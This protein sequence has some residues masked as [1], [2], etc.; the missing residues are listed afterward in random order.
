MHS[1]ASPWRTAVAMTTLSLL[2]VLYAMA[3]YGDGVLD[4][5][6]L[7]DFWLLRSAVMADRQHGGR[8]SM[9]LMPSH[10]GF[11][12]YRPLTQIAYF[13]ALRLL[14]GLDAT[15]FHLMQILVFA[16]NAILALAVARR[17]TAS[18][19]RGFAVALLYAAAPGH[20]VAVYWVAAFT[21]VGTA[22]VV[23]GAM[24]WW[25]STD[26]WVRAVGC[27]VLQVIALL[28][29]EHAAVLALLLALMAVFGRERASAVGALRQLGPASAVDLA[30]VTAKLWYFRMVAAP[31]GPYSMRFNGIDWLQGLGR[32]G[33]A[34]LNAATLAELGGPQATTF[35]ALIVLGA[36][37]AI[38]LALAGYARWRVVALGL[39]LFIVSLCP[40]LPLTAHYYDY[41]V[42][43]AAF[44]MALGIVGLCD[45]IDP[46]RG[47]A[48]AVGLALAV[49]ALDLFTCE[50][51]ARDNEVLRN[52]F[53]GQR[54]SA[55]LL[56]NLSA[57]RQ[58]VGVD[59]ELSIGRSP[60]TGYVL[61]QGHAQEVFFDPPVHISVI[62]G[63]T[64][65]PSAAAAVTHPVL[66][67]G[68]RRQ[69]FW[70]DADLQWARRL[71]PE[72]H[73]GYMSLSWG[74]R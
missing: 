29:S 32:Y 3:R 15:G 53:A 10:M 34:S 38:A 13:A 59:A 18:W 74:C 30:Y 58:T 57:T 33:A 67:A 55:D 12:L 26:G 23:F 44:G 63:R 40:V 22:F 65:S 36:A 48:L 66:S 50:R 24:L 20:A 21:M 45:A 11:V 19:M 1:S 14:F 51:A 62:G 47:G 25:L 39:G 41:Y 4:F 9:L 2:L 71:L 68:Q 64:Q 52:V 8:V 42:G 69:P 46:C 35:G 43:I 5:F 16:G 28:C 54:A 56:M 27:A 37:A 70:Q 73:R 72:L 7:D 6:F 17:L 31:L 49:I 60:V 61:D